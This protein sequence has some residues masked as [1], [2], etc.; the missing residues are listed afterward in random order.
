MIVTKSKKIKIRNKVQNNFLS[1]PLNNNNLISSNLIIIFLNF[2]NN[3]NNNFSNNSNFNHNFNNFSNHLITISHNNIRR[4]FINKVRK[5]HLLISIINKLINGIS[6]IIINLTVIKINIIK[7]KISIHITIRET[8]LNFLI[9]L[10]NK[11]N[12]SMKMIRIIIMKKKKM[13]I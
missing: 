8:I 12:Q 13:T 6:I 10:I 2:S 9:T 3:F 11:K 1:H 4:V 7:G 5:V